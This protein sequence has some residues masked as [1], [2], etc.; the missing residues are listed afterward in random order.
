[1][2]VV[3]Y[4]MATLVDFANRDFACSDWISVDQQIIDGFA[5]ATGDHQWIHVDAERCVKESP[6][7]APIAHGFL[8]LS[9]LAK[10]LMDV[11]L[12][13]VDATQAINVGVN[14]VRFFSPVREGKRVRARVKIGVV[15][16]KGKGRFLIE[17][18]NVLEVENEPDVALTADITVMVFG[19]THEK[20]VSNGEA[21]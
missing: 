4:R 16:D 9:L 10:L 7:G 3:N 20:G 6:F 15:Q 18:H 13:P 5:D 12:I 1:M 11:G 14:N 2:E 8:T 17:T 21:V 19:A